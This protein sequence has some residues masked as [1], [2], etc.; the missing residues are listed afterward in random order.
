MA[1]RKNQA[2]INLLPEEEFEG[3]TFGRTLRWAMSSFRIIVIVTEMVVMV[4]FL[5]RFWLDAR[6]A[7]LN[8]LIK[9][10][11][12]VLSA[13]SD[14]ERQF[15]NT[16]KKLKIFASLSQEEGFVSETLSAL[17]SLLPP[18]LSLSA[19]SFN[20]ESVQV[21]GVS[22]SET[23]IAQFIANLENSPRFEKVTLVGVDTADQEGQFTFTVK[24]IPKKGGG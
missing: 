23:G 15:K 12:A 4:V 20:K 18:D 9:Q 22:G 11:V 19:F 13:Q 3:T 10:K 16:Q 14:F 17:T 8:D 1:A 5:S 2:Q 21:K 7:D 24:A 6:N